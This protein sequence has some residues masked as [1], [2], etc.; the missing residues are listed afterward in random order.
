MSANTRS[1]PTGQWID[2]ALETSVVGSFT[3]LGPLLRRRFAHWEGPSDASGRLVVV[4]GASSGL[5]REA[6]RELGALGCTVVCVGRDEARLKAIVEEISKAGG[7]AVAEQADL[8]DLSKT[9]DLARRVAASYPSIDIL[10]HNAGALSNT[11]RLSP[12]G[13][14]FTVAVQ[15]LSPY[16]LTEL[17]R[18]QL[19]AATQSKVLTMTSGGMYTERFDL[20]TLEM[21]D[22]TYKG[23]VAYARAKRAQVVLTAAWQ[24]HEPENGTD[25]YAVH[26]G[27]AKT[28]GV[29]ESLPL[30]NKLLGPLLRSPAE[31]VDTLVWLATS[32]PGEPQGG[33]LWLDRKQRP[34]YRLSRTRADGPTQERQQDDLLAWLNAATAAYR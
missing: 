23:A 19:H 2:N 8:G 31:G 17:L 18:P 28:P 1:S 32:P 26:P 9:A 14:E 12:Q 10:I 6:A 7:N 25:F 13:H 27:W 5:G 11:R 22:A 29:A 3:K 21:S 30:F 24:R 4:T 16:L 20:E 15:L 34:I 33:G